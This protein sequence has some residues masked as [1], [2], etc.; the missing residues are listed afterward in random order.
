M[1]DLKIFAKTVELQALEQINT[2]VAQPAFSDCKVRIMPDV[3][4]GAGCVIGFTANLGSKIIP[5]IVGVDIGCGMY[6]VCI[7]RVFER[8]EDFA[9][10]D[11]FIRKH[12][13]SGF[14]VHSTQSVAAFDAINSLN[15]RSELKNIDHLLCSLGTLGGGNHFIEVAQDKDGIQYLI[16]HTGSRNLGKQVADI[17][18][19]KAIRSCGKETRDRLIKEFIAECK[20]NNMTNCIASGIERIKQTFPKIPDSL[21]YLENDLAGNYL[22]DMHTCIRFASENRYWIAHSIQKAIGYEP[23]FGFETIHNYIDKSGMVRKGAVAAHAGEQLLIPMNMRDGSLLCVGKG[24]PDW[25]FS[26]PH[27]A[28]RIMSRAAA[29]KELDEETYRKEMSGIYSTSVGA[30]TLD[31]SPMAYKPMKDIIEAIGDTVEIQHIL[32]PVYNFKAPGR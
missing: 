10:L 27:G 32:K 3:H 23:I 29:F 21:A 20:Q 17:Y 2:L 6:T 19:R 31:E 28:G 1:A 24:N 14:D 11:T 5:N 26:A 13:P 15:C 9:A 12:I 16:I 30:D 4:A 7:G 22:E 8:P 18:Q 25:N